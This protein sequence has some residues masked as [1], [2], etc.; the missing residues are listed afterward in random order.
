MPQLPSVQGVSVTC[1]ETSAAVQALRNAW[2]HP[3][4]LMCA[5]VSLYIHGCSGWLSGGGVPRSPVV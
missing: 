1:L 3:D 4:S 5:S 2:C